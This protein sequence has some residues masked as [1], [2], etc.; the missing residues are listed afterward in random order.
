MGK[1]SLQL[2]VINILIHFLF[3]SIG[4][5]IAK[6]LS[7]EGANVVISSR[8]QKNVDCALEE[9]KS[10]G[11]KVVGTVCHVSKQEHRCNLF[12]KVSTLII[13]NMSLEKTFTYISS[14]QTLKK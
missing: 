1:S 14:V 10:E 5:A 2:S 9:L 12:Q 6:R 11:L 13:V 4:F 3:I 8:K 7:R